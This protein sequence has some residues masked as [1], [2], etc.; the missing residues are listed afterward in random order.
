MIMDGLSKRMELVLRTFQ[1]GI[2]AIFIFASYDK[3]L[4]PGEFAKAISNYQILP[5][6]ILHLTAIILPWLELVCG[7]ALI[8]NRYPRAANLLVGLMTIVFTTAIISAMVRG[9]D[10]NCG[11]FSVVNDESNLGAGKILQNIGIILISLILELRFRGSKLGFSK[12]QD[13]AIS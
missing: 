6:A 2:G 3:I 9:L 7:V 1:V 11:C 5:L 13:S 4:N 10:I 8:I 12:T